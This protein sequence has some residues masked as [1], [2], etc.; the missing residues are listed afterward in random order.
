MTHHPEPILLPTSTNLALAALHTYRDGKAPVAFPPPLAIIEAGSLLA[1][2]YAAPGGLVIA[3][4]G[5][6]SFYDWAYNLSASKHGSDYLPG[7][8]HAGFAKASM[9]MT[10][11]LRQWLQR[12][13]YADCQCNIWL[14]GHSLGGAV[15]TFLAPWLHQRGFCVMGVDTYGSPRVGDGLYQESWNRLFAGVSHR[16]VNNVD[17]V[18]MLPPLLMGYRHVAGLNYFNR[19]GRPTKYGTLAGLVDKMIAAVCH[20]GRPGTAAVDNHAMARYAELLRASKLTAGEANG[21]RG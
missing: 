6:D 2:I 7:A 16:H 13:G 5:T 4:R 18:P 3:V 12:H 1:D 21:C 17:G 14:A 15:V 19:Q 11:P 20:I 9:H 8:I 10:V